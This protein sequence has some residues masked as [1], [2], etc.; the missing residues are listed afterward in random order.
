MEA[1]KD[2]DRDWSS[3]PPEVLNLI[4][5][6]LYEIIDFV[7]FRAVCK[8][9]RFSTPITD[10]PP[11]FPWIFDDHDDSHEQGL[12]FFSIS[13]SKFYTIHASKSLNKHFNE[14][15]DGYY[16]TLFYDEHTCFGPLSLINP[17]NNDCF[18]LPPFPLTN[19][20]APPF[21]NQPIW[22]GHGLNHKGEYMVCCGLQY[23][24]S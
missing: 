22:V 21:L 18:T 3:L 24:D 2:L 10:L 16:Y 8:A 1:G 5:K 6:Y 9:W 4:A 23:M 13:S 17:L 11:Q 14:S 12:R 19:D 20:G 15:F 7:Q